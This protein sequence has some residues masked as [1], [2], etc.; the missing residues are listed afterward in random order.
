[1][2]ELRSPDVVGL[3]PG[4][5]LGL[6]AEVVVAAVV[7]APVDGFP[8]LDP[9]FRGKKIFLNYEMNGEKK[10]SCIALLKQFNYLFE[11]TVCN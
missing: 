5:G 3:E 2:E 9:K 11:K 10:C 1:M 4:D 7:I 8:R 6:A